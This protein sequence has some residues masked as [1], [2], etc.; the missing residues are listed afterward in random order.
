MI[1]RLLLLTALGLALFS[2]AAAAQTPEHLRGTV[3]LLFG[4]IMAMTTKSGEKLSVS[5]DDATRVAAATKASLADVRPGASVGIAWVA[6]PDGMPRGLE[7]TIFPPVQPV[8]PSTA[9]W[10]LAPS[11]RMT[12]GTVGTVTGATSRTLTVNDGKTQQT[13]M[14]PANAPVVALGPGNRDMLA[15][16]V[17]IVVFA[18]KE[19]DGTLTAAAIVV[20]KDGAPPP[21]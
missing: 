8:K 11:S 2:A 20:G 1:A 4:D 18:R 14:V 9:P 7:V 19:K 13:I 21:M 15:P 17:P 3:D 10:D 5:L 12:N 16:E 6:Q